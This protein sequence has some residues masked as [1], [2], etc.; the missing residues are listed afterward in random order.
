[1]ESTETSG[2]VFLSAIRSRPE[3]LQIFKF[4]CLCLPPVVA[5]P[6]RF[7]VPVPGLV[8]DVGS[9]NSVVRSLQLS[10]VTVPNVSSLYKDPKTI[11]RVFRLL[12]RGPGL[13]RDR[14]FSIWNFLKGTEAMR[15]ALYEKM[16]LAY[17]KSVLR[18]E[19][20]PLFLDVSTPSV[21][22]SPSTSSSSNSGRNLGRVSLAVSRCEA[23]GAAGSSKKVAPK[24]AKSKKKSSA[25]LSSYCLISLPCLL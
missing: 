8:S 22:R 13:I 12:G 19:G 25:N 4:P 17:K 10:Y 2:S 21:S 11:C 24:T 18:G 6:V 15:T 16:E 1:M 23:D 14:K 9:F 3:L 7:C 5:E 20:L